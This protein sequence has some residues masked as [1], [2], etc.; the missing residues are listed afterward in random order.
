MNL[1]AT[2]GGVSRAPLIA[3]STISL[4]R[5]VSSA[6]LLIDDPNGDI[7][8]A[9]LDSVVIENVVGVDIVEDSGLPGAILPGGWMPGGGTP[10]HYDTGVV[11]FRG[12]VNAITIDPRG[13]HRK[14]S[15]ILKLECVDLNW[16]LDNPPN[17]LTKSYTGVSDRAIIL[18]ALT[19][20][21][22]SE[23]NAD[24]GT[25]GE[26]ETGLTVAFDGAT[27]R[28][29]LEEMVKIS[30]AV[31]WVEDSTLFYSAE[32]D[33]EAAAW[34]ID[35]D[36]PDNSATFDVQAMSVSSRH[37]YPLNSVTVVGPTGE[38]GSRASASA[39]DPTSI[40]TYGTFKRKIE[41]KSV[42]VDSYAQ[43][44]ADQL[45]EAGK[46]PRQTI[47]FGFDD[48][49]HEL[50][51][52]VNQKIVAT[53]ARFGLSS[54][55]FV[56]R[57]VR[58]Q[59]RTGSIS[60]FSVEAGDAR[61][62]VQDILKRLNAATRSGSTNLPQQILGLDFTRS[63]SEAVNSGTSVPNI[64]NLTDFTI[65]ATIRP[66]QLG[67]TQAIVAKDNGSNLGWMLRLDSFNN[68]EVSRTRDSVNYEIGVASGFSV[69]GVYKI[70]ARVTTAGLR[71][72]VNG[73]ERTVGGGAG[74]GTFDSETSAPLR[75]GRSNAGNYFDGMIARVA[76]WNIA[77]PETTCATL[78]NAKFDALPF[79]VNLKLAWALDEFSDGST[80]SGSDAIRDRSTSGYN[81]TP[82]NGP[83]GDI[84]IFIS[85]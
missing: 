78:H 11:I 83:E 65:V 75:V 66:D 32:D 39:S 47:R 42:T 45:V 56:T 68:L 18:D 60:D 67:V 43:L 54:Q 63:S 72:W 17:Y 19:V 40:S 21:G 15:R 76:L 46:D 30:G 9:T 49:S 52:T 13:Q 38:D 80:A 73:S 59:Q 61:P 24:S 33:A 2:I 26:I 70:V 3:G 16:R 4:R 44:A 81:G 48:A 14:G 29:V 77:L 58:I 79:G 64:D 57:E 34:G 31:W 12:F 1:T 62:S 25:I 74:S 82:V 27:M 37:D 50:F 85:D 53:S 6:S 41:L 84:S 71:L 10:T 20:L 23:I 69:G 7:V 55:A 35:T 28:D 51:L 8:I 5:P 22:L 36:A